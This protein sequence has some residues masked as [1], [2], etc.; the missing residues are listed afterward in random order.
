MKQSGIAR[1][2]EILKSVGAERGGHHSAGIDIVDQRRIVEKWIAVQIVGGE[3]TIARIG[4]LRLARERVGKEQRQLRMHLRSVEQGA[5]RPPIGKLRIK[6]VHRKRRKGRIEQRTVAGIGIVIEQPRGEQLLGEER[7]SPRVGRGHERKRRK[8]NADPTARHM[9]DFVQCPRITALDTLPV[10][11]AVAG[12]KRQCRERMQGEVTQILT[13][14]RH[15]NAARSL[16][17]TGTQ[18][19]KQ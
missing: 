19:R 13:L 4:V 17:G 14:G 1:R 12:R 16:T 3:G 15:H 8:R 7:L 11:G 9:S 2:I 6:R 10:L 5:Q 18:E